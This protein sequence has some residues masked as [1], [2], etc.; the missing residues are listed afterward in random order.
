MKI[1][2]TGA[3]GTGK[4]LSSYDLAVKTKMDHPLKSVVVVNEIATESPFPINGEATR[5][6]QLWIFT[7]QVRKELKLQAKYNILICDR[8]ICDSVAYCTRL[9]FTDVLEA[10]EPL[11]R[12]WLPTYD[13]IYFKRIETNPYNFQDGIREANNDEAQKIEDYLLDAYDRFDF[14]KERLI[15]C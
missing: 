15:F 7:N 5:E 10:I 1:A 14:P 9:G 6:S 2:F 11:V 13:I 4:S 8:C 3:Q 12:F